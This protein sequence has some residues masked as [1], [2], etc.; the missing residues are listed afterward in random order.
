MQ[1]NLEKQELEEVAVKK[2]VE[3]FSNSSFWGME[4]YPKNYNA[5]RK[6]IEEIVIGTKEK[7]A[8][9]C[10]EEY[11]IFIK[12]NNKETCDRIAKIVKQFSYLATDKWHRNAY[13]KI[14][15]SILKKRVL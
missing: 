3:K 6:F 15:N 2:Y 14:G 13:E 1:N 10:E 8:I 7:T 4:N 11:Q 9:F 5:I 12:E